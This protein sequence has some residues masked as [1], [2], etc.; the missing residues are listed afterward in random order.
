MKKWPLFFCMLLLAGCAR[1]S[2]VVP[3]VSECLH[4]GQVAA[5]GAAATTTSVTVLAQ[6]TAASTSTLETRKDETIMKI[7]IETTMGDIYADLYKAEAPKT[8]E[9]FAT[10]AKKGFYDGIIFH[11]V[12][13]DFMIQTGDPTG[14]GMGGPGYQFKDEFSK[15]LR[16]DKPGVLSMANSGPNTNGSQ[17]FITDAPTPWLDDR[18]SVF[19]QVTQGMDVVEKIAHAPRDRQDKPVQKIAMT[20]VT[21][22]ED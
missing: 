17:F 1:T 15:K 14:T 11:R 6:S 19:G 4:C 10:L 8:V 20:K 9:N 18:H 16:H 3:P 2:T 21:I 22:L 12:I 7:K 13:P 5:S